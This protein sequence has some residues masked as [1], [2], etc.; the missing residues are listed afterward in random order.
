MFGRCRL[1]DNTP[2]MHF[3]VTFCRPHEYVLE[4]PF[5]SK[6]AVNRLLGEGLFIH[7]NRILKMIAC[8]VFVN[9]SVPALR[10]FKIYKITETE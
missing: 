2:Y 5:S 7:Q 6:M 10:R 1:Q 8:V 9:Y 4:I 3:L